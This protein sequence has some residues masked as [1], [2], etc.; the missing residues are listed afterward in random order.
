MST[1]YF[2]HISCPIP[3]GLIDL[4]EVRV[5]EEVWQQDLYGDR[6]VA[7]LVGAPLGRDACVTLD[8]EYPL[9]HLVRV[10]Q[11]SCFRSVR[12]REASDQWLSPKVFCPRMSDR[13]SVRRQH[14]A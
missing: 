6:V 7:L 14:L 4:E 8:I 5:T 11:G 9:S 1:T 3:Y 10:N 13:N 12:C 2:G